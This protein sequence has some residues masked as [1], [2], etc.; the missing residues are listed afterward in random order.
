MANKQI[1]Q[2]PPAISLDGSEEVEIVQPAGSSGT[3]KRA[4]AAQIANTGLK[5]INTAIEYVVDEGGLALSTGV[6]GYLSVPFDA[7]ILSVM[8]LSDMTGSVSVDIWKCSYDAFDAGSSAPT[9]ADSITGGAYPTITSGTKY[10][11]DSLTSWTTFIESGSVL[12][13]VIDSA[14]DLTRLTISLG[15]ERQLD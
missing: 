12:A 11:T 3:S 8:L 7:E 6:K 9:V 1:T 4:T 13:F 2:L 5:R 14:T 10:E 15:V